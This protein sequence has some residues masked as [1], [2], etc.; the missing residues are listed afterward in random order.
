MVIKRDCQECKFE[1]LPD[2][3]NKENNSIRPSIKLALAPIYIVLVEC[4]FYLLSLHPR[5]RTV[6]VKNNFFSGFIS[7]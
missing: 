3:S 6:T 2:L 4:G 5:G 1:S 7:M